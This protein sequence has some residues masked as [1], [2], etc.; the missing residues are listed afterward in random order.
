MATKNI[1]FGILLLPMLLLQIQ[2]AN[3]LTKGCQ[4]KYAN[5]RIVCS[6]FE[7]WC[8]TQHNILTYEAYCSNITLKASDSLDLTSPSRF[9]DIEIHDSNIPEVKY[10]MFKNFSQVARLYI[11]TSNTKIIGSNAFAGLVKLDWLILKGNQI[12]VIKSKAFTGL[13]EL[14]VLNL[15]VNNIR[16]LTDDIFEGLTNVKYIGL[17]G[18]QIFKIG[19]N[20]FQK[21]KKLGVLFLENN[22]L[23]SISANLLSANSN[24]RFLWLKNNMITDIPDE[25]FNNKPYLKE[26]LLANNKLKRI[27]WDKLNNTY[28]VNNNNLIDMPSS[29]IINSTVL[30]MSFN[31]FSYISENM[32][33][34][35]QQ[36]EEVYFND[37][38]IEAIPSDVFAPLAKLRVLS[39]QNNKIEELPMGVFRALNKLETL[40]ISGNFLEHIDFGI[41]SGLS[42]LAK[43]DLSFNQLF[44]FEVSSIFTSTSLS[45]FYIQN[46]NLN[47][48]DFDSLLTQIKYL[49]EI[50][51]DNN[52]W[53]CDWLYKNL[54][55]L[56]SKRV[57]ILQGNTYKTHNIHGIS[58]VKSLIDINTPEEECTTCSQT[59]QKSNE[60]DVETIESSRF[61][62]KEENIQSNQFVENPKSEPSV[63][64]ALAIT[65]G[66]LILIVVLFVLV[67]V[68]KYFFDKK[69]EL[70]RNKNADTV[71][72]KMDLVDE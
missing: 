63:H 57:R 4:I 31:N 20:T 56:N 48:F 24:L 54:L 14:N 61:V 71:S 34:T 5:Y 70:H 42:N 26:V 29:I 33:N 11:E 38:S 35:S 3:S 17:R 9:Y 72:Y 41:F 13:S 8:N 50:N 21:L 45:G 47:T 12:S 30:D 2:E 10:G 68:K 58:C 52:K 46:N 51:L 49:K 53:N 18:N 69:Y 6:R 40:N 27:R 22:N 67:V 66:V 25:I 19:D 43:L 7:F 44:K 37:N 64:H 16:E 65:T 28:T 39:L 55:L 1:I 23:T 36:L 32:F 62:N 59:T 15:N 60:I